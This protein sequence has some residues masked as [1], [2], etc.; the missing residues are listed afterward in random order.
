MIRRR[1]NLLQ[2]WSSSIHKLT[3][4]LRFR[5]SVNFC[6][7]SGLLSPH[8]LENPN[9]FPCLSTTT[10]QPASF[11]GNEVGTCESDIQIFYE[12]NLAGMKTPQLSGSQTNYS[13]ENGLFSGTAEDN[14][15][16]PLQAFVENDSII[17]PHKQMPYILMIFSTMKGIDLQTHPPY[18]KFHNCHGFFKDFRVN[19]EYTIKDSNNTTLVSVGAGKILL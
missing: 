12:C 19:K 17:S 6:D 9:M 18:C 11:T 13:T 2:P 10:N 8:N 16:S 5:K 3:V 4:V 1:N 14:E 15:L 7:T